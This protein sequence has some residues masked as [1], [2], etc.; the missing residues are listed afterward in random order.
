MADDDIWRRRFFVFAGARLFGLLTIV[1]GVAVMFTDIVRP[2]GW[3]A[4]GAV[5]VVMGLI[6]AVVAPTLLRKHW[7][8]VDQ[9]RE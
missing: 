1:A 2:G 4:V 8:Q 9:E 5:I 3:P 6:D 7:R